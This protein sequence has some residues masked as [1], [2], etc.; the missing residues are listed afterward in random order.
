LCDDLFFERHSTLGTLSER[1]DMA[2]VLGLINQSERNDLNIIR[3]IRNGFAHSAKNVFFH[4]PVVSDEC[5]KLKNYENPD[6]DGKPVITAKAKYMA[7][8]HGLYFVFQ[9]KIIKWQDREIRSKKRTLKK[10]QGL[11]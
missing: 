5:D 9:T 10:L 8:V 3:R 2:Y 7:T 11:A 1:T 6:L 4:T